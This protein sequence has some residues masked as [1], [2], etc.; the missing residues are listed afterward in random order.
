MAHRG[1][2]EGSITQRKDGSWQ[3]ALQVEGKRWF[4]TGRTE[5]E[6]K[7]KLSDLKR[8]AHQNGALS[9][10]GTKTLNNLLGLWLKIAAPTLKSRTVHDY[11][12]VARRYVRPAIEHLRLTKISP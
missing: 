1:K 9:N 5:K 4:V 10:P 8:E 2:G 7:A 3:G 6:V 11:E 12:A